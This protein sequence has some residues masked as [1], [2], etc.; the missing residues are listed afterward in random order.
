MIKSKILVI[1]F[2]LFVQSAIA[3]PL[4]FQMG[5]S[6]EEIK[7]M[8]KKEYGYEEHFRT[9]SPGVYNSQYAPKP[10][11]T[12]ESYSLKIG[13]SGLCGIMAIGK[14]YPTYGSGLKS[15]F[16]K[17][18]DKL[19][20]AYGKPSFTSASALAKD[21]IWGRDTK[22][23]PFLAAWTNDKHQKLK[24]EL[25]QL[26]LA[27][28]DWWVGSKKGYIA[29]H[30]SFANESDCNKE[31]VVQRDKE[32]TLAEKKEKERIAKEDSAL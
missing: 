22:T 7:I 29:V 23:L 10:H 30:Y 19:V 21:D 4:G 32:K 31:L 27:S 2:G 8:A 12:F 14:S 17:M 5:M 13:S 1:I 15:R 20:I 25:V 18:K 16:E 9:D 6:F 26:T 11:P 3:E 28:V 24:G